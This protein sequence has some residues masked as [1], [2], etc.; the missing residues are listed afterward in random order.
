MLG[1]LVVGAHSQ[2]AHVVAVSCQRRVLLV[3]GVSVLVPCLLEL[4]PADVRHC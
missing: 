1:G 3:E 2:V 4:A